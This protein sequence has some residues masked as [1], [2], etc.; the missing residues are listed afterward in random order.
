MREWQYFNQPGF[1]MPDDLKGVIG[2]KSAL[3]DWVSSQDAQSLE[4]ALKSVSPNC[5]EEFDIIERELS[6]KRHQEIIKDRHFPWVVAATLVSLAGLPFSIIS[7]CSQK[8][9]EPKH[10]PTI[11]PQTVRQEP[12][13]ATYESPTVRFEMPATQNNQQAKE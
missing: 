12:I 4:V 9:E 2:D 13:S 8:N 6:A 10:T 7:A 1:T 5:V 3:I 11:A